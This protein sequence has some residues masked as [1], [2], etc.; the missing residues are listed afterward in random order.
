LSA[1]ETG[2]A[3]DSVSSIPRDK[4]GP[5]FP[6]PWA[7]R[8]F[9]MAVAL[10]ERGVFPWSEWSATLG[11]HVARVAAN[12]PSDAEAYW[13]AWLSTLEEILNPNGVGSLTALADL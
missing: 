6:A 9:A 10:N 3:L 5:V 12:D 1:S 7:A 11:P 13:L 2:N 4:E 8:V